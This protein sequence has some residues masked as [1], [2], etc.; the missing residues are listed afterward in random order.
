MPKT[1]QWFKT[2]GTDG[3]GPFEGGT[4]FPNAAANTP[5]CCPAR[6]TIFTGQYSHNNGQTDTTEIRIGTTEAAAKQQQTLQAYLSRATPSYRTGIF[7]KYLNGWDISC[8][9]PPGNSAVPPPFFDDYAIFNFAYSPTCVNENGTEKQVWRYSTR[10]VTEKALDFLDNAGNQPW[11]LYVAPYTPHEPFVPEANDMDAPVPALTETDSF[12]ENDRTDKP[13]WLREGE[14]LYDADWNRDQFKNQLRMLRSADDMVDA[15]M[16]KVRSLGQ[17]E[18]TI[19]FFTSDNGYQWGDHG[20]SGKAR[21]YGS[22]IDVPLFVRWPGWTGHSGN[23]TDNRIVGHVDLAP[24]ALDVAGITPGGGDQKD[25]RTLLDTSNP[26]KRILTEVAGGSSKAGR[27]SSIHTAD[28]RYTENYGINVDDTTNYSNPFRE[29]YDLTRDPLELTNLLGDGDLTNDPPIQELAAAVAS[30]RACAGAS[31][32]RGGE[33]IPLEAR[34]TRGPAEDVFSTGSSTDDPATSGFIN[35][36]F[37]FTSSEPRSRFECR[38]EALNGQYGGRDWHTCWSPTTFSP[39]VNG[40]YRFSVRAVDPANPARVSPVETYQW[41]VAANGN[42]DTR[43]VLTPPRRAASQTA[44][45]S[46]ASSKPAST[47][48]CKLDSGPYLPCPTVA[49]FAVQ[50]TTDAAPHE[51]RVVASSA[52]GEDTTPALFRWS[53]DSTP[54]TV[55]NFLVD[56]PSYKR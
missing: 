35:G 30:D 36:T 4:S 6:A 16:R 11:F 51:L 9:R 19:A 43:I 37:H 55:S 14:T 1:R 18:N 28:F 15:V 2:G 27:W 46:F 34:I 22:S 31:C 50:D 17:D 29:Y 49:S 23:Q 42:P 21:P 12:F 5:W 33:Q 25:G 3:S 7:G 41:T 48:E 20:A 38:L 10:Y 44:W 40:P 53:V 54:L 26:R 56:T 13:P 32:P 47:F 39:F 52:F 45:F 24:T 8:S